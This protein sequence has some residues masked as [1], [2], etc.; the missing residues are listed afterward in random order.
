M[1]YDFWKLDSDLYAHVKASGRSQGTTHEPLQNSVYP[2]HINSCDN[3]TASVISQHH[4]QSKT[5]HCATSASC[6]THVEDSLSSSA[7]SL[8]NSEKAVAQ[9]CAHS[10]AMQY[11]CYDSGDS[12][13]Y[14]YAV[15][16]QL[17]NTM[18]HATTQFPVALLHKHLEDTPH[19]QESPFNSFNVSESPTPCLWNDSQGQCSFTADNVTIVMKHISSYHLREYQHPDCQVQCR[20]RGCLLRRTIRRDTILRHIREKHYG[21]KFRRRHSP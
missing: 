14:L 3:D 12:P 17:A 18:P 10:I 1:P 11:S 7:S 9:H 4:A 15:N 20:C 21:D 5:S 2:V 8:S 13:N 19:E 6:D 16:P